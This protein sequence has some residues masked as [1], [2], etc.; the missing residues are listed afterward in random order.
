MARRGPA[1][2]AA[3]GAGGRLS[4][5]SIAPL[6]LPVYTSHLSTAEDRDVFMSAGKVYCRV[7]RPRRAS[8]TRKRMAVA[9]PPPKRMMGRR[10]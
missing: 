2:R 6:L 5:R 8:T 7:R 1:R 9:G 10:R 3:A 4:A